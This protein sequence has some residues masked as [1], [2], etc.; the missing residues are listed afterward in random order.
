M[1]GTKDLGSLEVT[2][3]LGRVG[4][5]CW[6]ASRPLCFRGGVGG[7]GPMALGEDKAW[8]VDMGDEEELRVTAWGPGGARAGVRASEV[9]ESGGGALAGP[10][11]TGASWGAAAG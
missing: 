1:S 11:V 7:G 10:E 2:W 5:A 3:I 6:A 4:S 9:G 8:L